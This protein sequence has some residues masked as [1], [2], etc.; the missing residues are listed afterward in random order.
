MGRLVQ[1]DVQISIE[2][3]ALAVQRLCDLLVKI[4]KHLIKYTHFT[5]RPRGGN[6]EDN[7]DCNIIHTWNV[8]RYIVFVQCLTMFRDLRAAAAEFYIFTVMVHSASH[9]SESGITHI[10]LSSTLPVHAQDSSTPTF[11]KSRYFLSRPR[12]S[13]KH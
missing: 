7:S 2:F 9:F 3:P 1:T 8:V 5:S 13:R 4:S 6:A 10:C 12:K 11:L